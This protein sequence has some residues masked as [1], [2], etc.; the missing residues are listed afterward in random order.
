M[1]S[2]FYWNPSKDIFTLPIIDRPVAWYGFFFLLGFLI[3]YYIIIPI[4]SRYLEEN[5]N[6]APSEIPKTSRSIVDKLCWFVVIGTILGARLGA[7]FFYDW[8]YFKEHPLEIFKIWNPG[9]ASHGGVTGVFISLCLFTFYIK[10]KI[11]SITLLS[12]MDAVAIPSALVAAFIRLGN[13]VNQEILGVQTQVPWGV[14]FGN[15]ADGSRPVPRH[16]VQLYE[17]FCYLV[18]FF[19][20]Y[21]IWKKGISKIGTGFISGMMFIMIFGTRFIIEYWKETQM[22]VVDQSF[23]QMGQLLSIPFIVIGICLILY[24]KNLIK[25]FS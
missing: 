11:P 8:D 5:T 14:V 7:V 9:L 4:F 13:F 24:K 22:A 2:W 1:L 3:S 12:L 20:L 18:T 6:M 23:L 25:N 16:P 19:V 21:W 17:S 10:K 15:P